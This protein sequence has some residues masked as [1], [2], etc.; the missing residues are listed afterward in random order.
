MEEMEQK[1][2][3]EEEQLQQQDNYEHD[4][5]SD[6]DGDDDGDDETDDEDDDYGPT[7]A[8]GVWAG[9]QKLQAESESIDNVDA[10][11]EGPT[12]KKQRTE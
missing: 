1:R 8:A 4:K 10:Q 12:T 11:E 3:R 6:D 7:P 2:R 5:D 9:S